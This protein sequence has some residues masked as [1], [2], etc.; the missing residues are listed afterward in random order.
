MSE[1][2]PLESVS[3]MVGTVS[4]GGVVAVANGRCG[5][6]RNQVRGG[7]CG[8]PCAGQ[9][10]GIKSGAGSVVHRAQVP[11]PTGLG[12]KTCAM[13]VG[14]GEE[15][16]KPAWE[17]AEEAATPVR[18]R[19]LVE[20]S[21]GA[22]SRKKATPRG[23]GR[24]LERPVCLTS[25]QPLLALRQRRATLRSGPRASLR[26][27]PEPPEAALR[28]DLAGP[29]PHSQDRRDL[30][31]PAVSGGHQGGGLSRALAVDQ[32]VPVPEPPLHQVR[33][34]GVGPPSLMR[35]SLRRVPCRRGP[36]A[37]YPRPPPA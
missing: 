11:P 7:L 27:G 10:P 14:L 17:R 21:A 28:D 26:Q 23:P 36:P 35:L 2:I 19:C 1:T 5:I 31:R 33:P 25:R 22:S 30:Q 6:P 34:L 13:R 12:E 32:R 24:A 18:G 37:P 9:A 3:P 29:P 15:G 8:R 20:R 16:S 4:L